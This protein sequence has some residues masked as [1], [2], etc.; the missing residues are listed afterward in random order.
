MDYYDILGVSKNSTQDDIKKAYRKLA[1]KFHPDKHPTERE[2]Y[3]AKFKEISEAYSVLS[4]EEKRAGYDQ[5]GKDFVNMEGGS[6]GMDPRD[7]FKNFFGFGRGEEE[8]SSKVV[9]T[10]QL[11]LEKIYKGCTVKHTYSRKIKCKGCNGTGNND[12]ID[13]TC[14]KCNGKK[15]V[16]I[17]KQ[18]GIMIQQYQTKCS[19]CNGTGGESVSPDKRCNQC[20][21]QKSVTEIC[22]I[23]VHVPPD[24]PRRSSCL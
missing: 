18:M 10:I 8:E 20:V 2:K 13:R 5:F 1:M 19:L 17:M 21:G 12:K 15:I 16:T 23:D 24:Y 6:S 22:H 11:P 14:K 4:D 7:I 3:E 9:E